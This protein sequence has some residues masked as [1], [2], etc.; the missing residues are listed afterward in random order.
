LSEVWV[1]ANVYEYELPWLELGQ[2]A[3]VELSYLPG[4]K[5]NGTVTYI[6]PFLDPKTRTAEIRVELENSK[7]TLK[8]EMFGN[9]VIAGSPR[10]DALVIPSDAVIHS[11]RRT[12]AVVALGDGLFE[13]RDV[14]LGLDS[15]D[16]WS[17]VLSG[18]R[19]GEEI[20]VSSQFLIDSES[21]LR[22]AVRKLGGAKR[23][24]TEE[25][26]MDRGADDPAPAAAAERPDSSLGGEPHRLGKE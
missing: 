5:F 3:R 12:L 9:V 19:V 11:G 16:G 17:E 1:L 15:G 6:A 13:P 20:V 18:I 4:E 7:R 24:A 23:A 14:E 25:D 10:S 2:D 22:E 26:V 8:P 21:N